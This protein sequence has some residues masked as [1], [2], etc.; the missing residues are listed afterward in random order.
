MTCSN[1]PGPSETVLIAD[2]TVKSCMFF[3]NHLHPVLS[4]LSYDG[5]I[6]TTLVI[7]SDVIQDVDLVQ[8]F[9]MKSLALLGRDFSVNV[10]TSIDKY[11]YV[12]NTS[13]PTV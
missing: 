11:A 4:M 6:Y 1:V 12:S 3:T 13:T 9:F 2:A 8:S 10:P 5:Q 7:D